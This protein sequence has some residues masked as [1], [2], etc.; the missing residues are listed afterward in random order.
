MS[1][2]VVTRKSDGQEVTRY[3]AMQ[4]VEQLNDL[5]VPFADFDHVEFVEGVQP[6]PINPAN[7]RIWVGSFFDRFGAHKIAILADPDPVVQAIVKDATVRRYID[8]IERR[9]ELGQAIALLQSKGHAVDA[10]AIL[11]LEPTAS[12]VWNG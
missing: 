3:A 9:G 10:T 11:D 7:W 2:F 5:V 8:L 6:Q 1:T 12:E 4:P